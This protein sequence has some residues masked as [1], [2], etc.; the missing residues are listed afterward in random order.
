[1]S[2]R[3][4]ERRA[5]LRGSRQETRAVRVLEFEIDPGRTIRR[6]AELSG[7]TDVD[8]T[9]ETACRL[10]ERNIVRIARQRRTT[11]ACVPLTKFLVVEI[12]RYICFLWSGQQLLYF[13]FGMFN[14]L[15][16]NLRFKTSIRNH[17]LRTPR[18]Y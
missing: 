16:L 18:S 7:W 8:R 6:R 2:D 1:M 14:A 4:K 13:F 15:P 11:D 12:S 17:L 3:I 9:L 10:N 5:T